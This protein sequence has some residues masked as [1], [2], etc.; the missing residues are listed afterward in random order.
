M[1]NHTDDVRQIAFADQSADEDRPLTHADEP[2]LAPAADPMQQH[3]QDSQGRQGQAGNLS[4]DNS[5]ATVTE[6]PAPQPDNALADLDLMPDRHG[7][8]AGNL[9]NALHVLR[10]APQW[11]GVLAYDEFGTAVVTRRAPPWGGGAHQ[12]WTD[13]DDTR[14]C[15]WFQQHGI[16]VSIGTVG[17]AVET[18]AREALVH[19]VREYLSNLKWDGNPRIETWLTRYLGVDD[20]PYSRAVGSRFLILGMARIFQP[21]CQADHVLILEGAQGIGKSSALRILADPWFTDRVA[22][23]GTRDAAI[24]L[25]GVMLAEVAELDALTRASNTAIKSFIARRSDHFRPPYGRRAIKQPR[26]CVFAGTY[27]PDGDG[28]YLKEPTGARRFWPVACGAIRLDLLARDRDQLWAEAVV[29]YR[30]GH[31]W[32]LDS[33]ELVALASAEQR[34]RFPVDPWSDKVGTWLV[35][36]SDIGVGEVLTEALGI[37]AASHSHTAENRVVKILKDAGFARYR[38]GRIGAPRTPR[39]RREAGDGIGD[40][41]QITLQKKTPTKGS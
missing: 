27:N 6:N 1:A 31:R 11:T 40:L 17:R 36:R 4:A 20:T 16:S 39:Y 32:W 25:V 2:T 15:E 35:G 38:P 30:Q 22:D 10:R 28:G 33:P 21:S 37:A 26:Q 41:R 8:P 3:S 7:R 9:V 24:G 14:G 18:V 12:Q 29:R 19:P 23:L 34:L 5:A 13:Q